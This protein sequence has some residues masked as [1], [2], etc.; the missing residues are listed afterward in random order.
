MGNRSEVWHDGVI[1]V[2]TVMTNEIS[3]IIQRSTA[4]AGWHKSDSVPGVDVSCF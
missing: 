1:L 3:T 2:R 4:V